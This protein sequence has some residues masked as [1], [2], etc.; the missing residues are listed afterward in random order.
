MHKNWLLLPIFGVALVINPYLACSSED[1][2]DFTYSEADMKEALLG[3]WQGTAELDGEAVPFS[4]VLEQS[5][6][7]SSPQNVAAP[8]VQ[9]Q[10]GSRS[11]VKPAG[12]CVSFSTMPVVGTLTSENPTLN[13]AVE[14][15]IA[16]YRNLEPAELTLRLEDGKVLSGMIENQS[17]SAGQINTN[18]QLGTFSLSRP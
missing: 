1:E 6:A 16:A 12:A 9:P 10:C 18:V 8:K 5:S 17:L 4:L 2:S 11:F 7:K 3:I 15:D 13:G 14:G